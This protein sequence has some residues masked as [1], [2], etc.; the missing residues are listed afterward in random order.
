MYRHT[1]HEPMV[2]L[3]APTKQTTRKGPMK[4]AFAVLSAVVFLDWLGARTMLAVVSMDT[5]GYLL[6]GV[7]IV[8]GAISSL[9]LSIA[10]TMVILNTDT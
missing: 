10:L 5:S 2:F 7:F 9:L 6:N 1:M 3:V 8:W 4:K